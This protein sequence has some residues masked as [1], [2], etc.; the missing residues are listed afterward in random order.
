MDLDSDA[1]AHKTCHK[2]G[3][4]QPPAHTEADQ[5]KTEEPR[6]SDRKGK[7]LTEG[8]SIQYTDC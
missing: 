7:H 5:T 8:N 1:Q 2:C 4:C 6:G 3:E